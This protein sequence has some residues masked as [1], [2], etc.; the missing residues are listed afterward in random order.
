VV[1]SAGANSFSLQE[2][3]TGT[4][5]NV[6]STAY[7][8]YSG[9]GTVYKIFEIA[10]PYQESDLPLLRWVQSVDTLYLLHPNYEPRKLVR[11]APLS[12]ALS[13]VDFVDGPYFELNTTATTLTPS[14][15]TGSITITASATAGINNGQGFLATDVG[16]SVRLLHGSTWG[17]A[18]I[19][20]VTSATQV[21][22]TVRR[23]LGGT[24]ATQ[25]WRLGLWSGTTGYPSFGTFYEARLFLG[26]ARGSPQR[27]DGSKSFL[28]EDFSPSNPSGTVA[29]DNAV[30]VVLNSEDANVVRWAAGTEKGLLVGTTA[31]EWVV[32]PSS[33]NE[34]LSPTN[35][36]AKVATRN[37][38][39]PVAPVV[40][41]SAVLYVQR[42]GT[43]LREMA[44]V[45][46]VDG[47]RSPDMTVI[48]E[49]LV[50]SPIVE[51]TMTAQ[52][53]PIVWARRADG[54]LLGFTYE[55]DR[56]ATAWHQHELGGASD[57]EGTLIPVVEAMAP[58]IVS[59][60]TEDQLYLIVRRHINGVTRRYVEFLTR[61][62]QT[63]DDAVGAFFVDCGATRIFSPTPQATLAGLWHLE[64]QQ[65]AILADGAVE[66]R[67]TV[68]NGKVTLG[69][70]VSVAHVGL[71]YASEARTLPQVGAAPD[72]DPMT[73]VRRVH[74]VG[75]F[76]LD[77]ASFNY[78]VPGGSR[79]AI[80]TRFWGEEF[81]APPA[82]FTG[83]ARVRLEDDYTRIGQVEWE[84]SDPV[85][86]TVLAVATQGD[87]QD[88]S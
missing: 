19:T 10:S 38:S 45:F 81:G 75:F 42:T 84:V 61:F 77:T 53:Q 66:P 78:G 37:G 25:N 4:P 7:D 58:T 57:P 67:A 76:L 82:L 39:Y 18:K 83:V 72:G 50:H 17:W 41:G 23:D 16:R 85:P 1:A 68:S 79:T 52:P 5:V 8:T 13:T 35:V 51:L 2:D 14:G 70:A 69:R 49:H 44:Y 31:A 88:D 87:V 28:P 80:L 43:R 63:D 32:R 47:F 3:L 20:A 86:A 65:V 56:G 64:G 30:A 48:A 36:S 33:L 21:T 40:A 15:T 60:G 46:E 29:N 11:T 74:R 55:R 9:G 59:T 24:A 12:W 62:W 34:A 6:N 27:L 73:K 71:P 54:A 26:G 22:A